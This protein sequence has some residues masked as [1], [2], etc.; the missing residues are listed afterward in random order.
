MKATQNVS[1]LQDNATPSPFRRI[2]TIDIET[3]SLDPAEPK[4]AYEGLGLT[5]RI[6]AIGML[7]DDG[8]NLTELPLADFDERRLLERFW[9]TVDPGDL[10]VGHTLQDFDLPFIRQRSW[11]LGVHPSRNIDM[12]KYYTNDVVDV[13]AL[14]TNWS[15]R[16]KGCSL[17]NMAAALGCGAKSGHGSEVAGMWAARDLAAISAYCMQDV[18]LAYRVY[19]RLM[20]REPLQPAASILTAAS[21]AVTLPLSATVAGSIPPASS[22]VLSQVPL[23]A[24][25]ASV[26][27]ALSTSSPAVSV[28]T[29]RARIAR[30]RRKKGTEIL[31]VQQNG[32]LILSGATFP[33]KEGLKDL[34]ARGNKNP[35]NSYEW[36]VPVQNYEAVAALCRVRG[37]RLLATSNGSTA[38][39][40]AA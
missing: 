12:R 26:P 8:F 28:S 1:H 18:R 15:G 25:S 11:I 10:L 23:F 9:A 3:V 4:G 19:C 40:P 21:P 22:P 7:F 13:L 33:I 27:P 35:D 17:D 31:C 6:V 36:H 20:F 29:E 38:S 32:S 37:I 16:V 24:L 5:G 14:W 39:T 30:P 34:G 2:L